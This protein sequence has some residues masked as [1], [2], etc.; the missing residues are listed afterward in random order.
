MRFAGGRTGSG[1]SLAAMGGYGSVW[2]RL[3]LS[4]WARLAV[5]RPGAAWAA[6][7]DSDGLTLAGTT[8][9]C[10]FL[11]GASACA[12]ASLPPHVF[13]LHRN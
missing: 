7:A 10:A 6:R 9:G 2:P 4:P 3:D 13:R 12:T 11:L 5:A 8:G 1:G